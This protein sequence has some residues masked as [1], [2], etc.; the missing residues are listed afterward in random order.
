MG[1]ISDLVS[2]TFE[3]MLKEGLTRY[4]NVKDTLDHKGF[5]GHSLDRV[6][7]DIDVSVNLV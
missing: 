5:E 7:E 2:P 1:Y 3:L 6:I 4:N